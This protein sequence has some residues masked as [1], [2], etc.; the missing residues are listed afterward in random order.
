MWSLTESRPFRFPFFPT[1]L[2]QNWNMN[3]LTLV[4]VQVFYCICLRFV[5][6]VLPVQSCE[7]FLCFVAIVRVRVYY[8]VFSVLRHWWVSQVF[9]PRMSRSSVIL[10]WLFSGVVVII[11]QII[12][13]VVSM[14]LSPASIVS[15]QVLLWYTISFC[16]KISPASFQLMFSYGCV[17]FHSCLVSM[18]LFFCASVYNVLVSCSIVVYW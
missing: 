18:I 16:E 10:W 2:K 8:F 15:S 14:S 3:A 7:V 6:F 13:S 4:S 5:K 9:T 12:L 17:L 11:I 1:L